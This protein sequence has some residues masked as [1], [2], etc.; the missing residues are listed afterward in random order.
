MQHLL[1][2]LGASLGGFIIA[3]KPLTAAWNAFRSGPVAAVFT[4]LSIWLAGRS[5]VADEP[6]STTIAQSPRRRGSLVDGEPLVPNRHR[7][8]LPDRKRGILPDCETDGGMVLHVRRRPEW[9]PFAFTALASLRRETI[10]IRLV[11]LFWRSSLSVAWHRS[12]PPKVRRARS[13]Q[14]A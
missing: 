8:A 3:E 14:I 12:R 4:L 2:G 7:H 10:M 5:R 11:S 6:N 13:R 9:V 1:A